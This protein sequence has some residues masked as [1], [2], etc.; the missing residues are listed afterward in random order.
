MNAAPGAHCLQ[1]TIET[2]VTSVKELHERGIVSFEL[3]KVGKNCG[4]G[5]GTL[6]VICTWV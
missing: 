1:E 3:A 6:R 2:L 4:G 5:P